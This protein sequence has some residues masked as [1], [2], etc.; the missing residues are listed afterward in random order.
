MKIAI[1]GGTGS[2]GF[3]LAVRLAKAYEVTIGSRDLPRA[4]EAAA[5]AGAIARMRVE[6]RANRE[7]VRACDIAI[8]AVPDLPPSGLFES[9]APDLAEKLVISP[10]VPMLFKDGIFSISHPEE[11]AAERVAKALPK[12]KVAGAFHTVPAPKLAQLAEALDYDVLVTADSREVFSLASRVVSSVGKL[13]PLYA[14]PLAVS[15]MVEAMT[16]ALLNVSKLNR[17]DNP[18]IKL[19]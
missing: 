6:A 15:R 8:L 14:G 3:G 7:A 4:T 12:A 13:R 17:L 11:S 2:L 10:I 16:P 5:K 19:V 18:S 1:I 9:L